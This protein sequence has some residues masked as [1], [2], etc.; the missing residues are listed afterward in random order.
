M[1]LF[2]SDLRNLQAESLPP[3]AFFG[4]RSSHTPFFW[5]TKFSK[6]TC[7]FL[8]I[9]HMKCINVLDFDDRSDKNGVSPF[10]TYGLYSTVLVHNFFRPGRMGN[11]AGSEVTRRQ[12]LIDAEW[13]RRRDLHEF[14]AMCCQNLEHP[15]HRKSNHL[16]IFCRIS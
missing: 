2:F 16:S 15:S 7:Y 4:G 5:L 6:N 1:E 9:I 11:S 3:F 10:E 14:D 13:D 8:I 12:R